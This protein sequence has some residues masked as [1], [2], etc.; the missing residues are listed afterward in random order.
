VFATDKFKLLGYTKLLKGTQ[1]VNVFQWN[2]QLSSLFGLMFEFLRLYV[3]K[4][5]E[6]LASMELLLCSMLQGAGWG[7]LGLNEGNEWNELEH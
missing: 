2:K 4:R 1:F 3:D 7:D 6:V 5:K